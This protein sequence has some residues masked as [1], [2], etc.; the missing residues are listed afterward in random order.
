MFGTAIKKAATFFPRLRL[1]KSGGLVFGNYGKN[2][3][4][5]STKRASR[6]ISAIGKAA[7]V[8]IDKAARQYATAHDL[9]RSFGSRWAKRLL[10]AVLKELMRHS[11]IN[12]TM[13]YYVQQTAEDVGD[14][15]RA[16]LGNTC[17]NT[18]QA[19][20]K[21]TKVTR[22]ANGVKIKT[23]GFCFGG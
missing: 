23:Y 18:A 1:T 2:V 11:S 19:E 16:S 5:L 3:A 17:G 7:S 22:H 14:M 20:G 10:P 9:R 15:L 21:K 8:V 13:K 12:T 4:P 6:C